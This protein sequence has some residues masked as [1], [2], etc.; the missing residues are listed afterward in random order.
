MQ[1]ND[2]ANICCIQNNYFIISF[3][4]KSTVL[5]TIYTN[6]VSY[7]T[8]AQWAPLVEN[9]I[10][11]FNGHIIRAFINQCHYRQNIRAA[12]R[13]SVTGCVALLSI[14]WR[15]QTQEYPWEWILRWHCQWQWQWQDMCTCSQQST[16]PLTSAIS[17]PYW[18]LRHGVNCQYSR[19]LNDLHLLLFYLIYQLFDKSIEMES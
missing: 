15:H 9:Q 5:I 16:K 7:V 12:S 14:Q 11:T 2:T 18:N 13:E 17:F 19:S 10:T 6:T 8:G 1:F 4:R 3:N